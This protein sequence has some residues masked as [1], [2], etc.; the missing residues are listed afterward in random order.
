MHARTL[1]TQLMPLLRHLDAD[2]ELRASAAA[3]LAQVASVGA[4]VAPMAARVATLAMEL[5]RQRRR[6]RVQRT[7]SSVL[8]GLEQS[9]ELA[10]ELINFPI[11]TVDTAETVAAALDSGSSQSA[12]LL[13][14]E[15]PT[16]SGALCSHGEILLA[17]LGE[18][19][20]QEVA[21]L[22]QLRKAGCERAKRN[23]LHVM[24]LRSQ[25]DSA[26]TAFAQWHTR[27]SGLLRL[28]PAKSV[29]AADVRR[30]TA[31]VRAQFIEGE[32]YQRSAAKALRQL[33]AMP[34]GTEAATT[35]ESALWV[36]RVTAMQDELPQLRNIAAAM[37]AAADLA[38]LLGNWSVTAPF[39]DTE[40]LHMCAYMY[41]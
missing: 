37:E 24:A 16:A 14:L 6:A 5:E 25:L 7:Y 39:E 13:A 34:D 32:A 3:S 38:P 12:S 11:D 23:T 18:R 17:E 36:P 9:I 33:G 26:T 28:R 22:L 2:A 1:E 4:M 31:I 8:A 29:A 35:S 40:G 10:C 20:A 15:C 30:A 27:C 21:I 41:M 19:R